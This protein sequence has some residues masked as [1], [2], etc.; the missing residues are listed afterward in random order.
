[1]T[2]CPDDY[3]IFPINSHLLERGSLLMS[4]YGD[5]VAILDFSPLKRIIF[6]SS[7]KNKD[8]WGGNYTV[9]QLI[10]LGYQHA[11]RRK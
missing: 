11:V 4:K 10:D 8:W 7:V 1:M 2:N 5:I 3:N 6:V 9:Q